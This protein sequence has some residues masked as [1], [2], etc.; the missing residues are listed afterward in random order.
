MTKFLIIGDLHGN[1]P[2][3]HFKDFDAIIAPGDFCSDAP[4]RYMFASL[5]RE[6]EGK[7]S[8]RWYDI[9]G[10]RKAREMV[11]KSLSDGRVILEYLNSFGVPIYLVPGNWDWT[12]DED[13]DWVFLRD[14]HYEQL[15]DG[16]CNVVDIHCGHISCDG[17][18]MIG[19][20]LSTGPEYPQYKEDLDRFSKKELQNKKNRYKHNFRKFSYLFKRAKN[21]VIFLSHNVPFNTPLDKIVNKKS[22]RDGQ[23]FGSLLSRELIERYQPLVCIGGHMHEHFGK[24]KI[25]KTTVINSGFG[26]F[27]NVFLEIEKG[28]VKK[29]LFYREG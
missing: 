22:P 18:D 13:A 5:K 16:L 9:V 24:C 23:H 17:F 1:K 21:P 29:L 4:R 28:K 11:R 10:R 7:S 20:G 27:V 3:I 19:Y 25:G 8:K 12:C 26:P 6:L 15:V 2:R 14:N